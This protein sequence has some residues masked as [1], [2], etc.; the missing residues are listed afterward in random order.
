MINIIYVI[1][2]NSGSDG[3]F[4]PLFNVML[5]SLKQSEELK[6]DCDKH[7]HSVENKC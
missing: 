7:E 1:C 3:G 2:N 5:T 6:T 4:V